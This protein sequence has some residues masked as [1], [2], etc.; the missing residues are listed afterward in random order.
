MQKLTSKDFG[1]KHLAQMQADH[2]KTANTMAAHQ[3][4][5]NLIMTLC[6]LSRNGREPQRGSIAQ[7]GV[8]DQREP[9][10]GK[11][12]CGPEPQ[13]GSTAAARLAPF[14][15]LKGA[16]TVEPRWGS[17]DHSGQTRG[18][19]PLVANPRLCYGTPLGFGTGV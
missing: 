7:P 6:L 13:R 1:A 15:R 12:V 4:S 16:T 11:P 18:R 2:Q 17:A 8:G 9:T 19:L 5:D 10:P 3:W 14:R